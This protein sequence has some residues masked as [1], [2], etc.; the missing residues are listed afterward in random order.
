M[1]ATC[2]HISTV[3]NSNLFKGGVKTIEDLSIIR[4]MLNGIFK[5]YVRG[6]YA[7]I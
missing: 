6:R 1:N 7:Y 3:L 2:V 4:Y 5:V